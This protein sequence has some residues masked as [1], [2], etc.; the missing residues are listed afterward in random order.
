MLKQKKATQRQNNF[1]CIVFYVVRVVSDFGSS[2]SQNLLFTSEVL[3]VV[4][5]MATIFWI[6]TPCHS[7]CLLT[8]L[9]RRLRQYVY[10]KHNI[11]ISLLVYSVQNCYFALSI[12]RNVIMVDGILVNFYIS[13]R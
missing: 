8:V 10:P 12:R 2:S 13:L 5:I 4:N 3:N 6:V 9:P 7:R 1:G 11:V